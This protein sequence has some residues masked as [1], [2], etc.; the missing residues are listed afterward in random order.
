[1]LMEFRQ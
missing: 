1:M